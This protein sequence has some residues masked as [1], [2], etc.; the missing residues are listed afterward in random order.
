MFN[1]KMYK[2]DDLN[3]F[4]STIRWVYLTKPSRKGH[5]ILRRPL[6]NNLFRSFVF[7]L[8]LVPVLHC[9]HTL[10]RRPGKQRHKN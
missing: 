10:Y 9:S 1:L 6:Y 3:N 8:L 2:I 7:S 5:M 4:S